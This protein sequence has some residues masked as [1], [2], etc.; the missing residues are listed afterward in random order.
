MENDEMKIMYVGREKRYSEYSGK[1]YYVENS[2]PFALIEYDDSKPSEVSLFDK[3]DEVLSENGYKGDGFGSGNEIAIYY[4]VED[5]A[6]YLHL[7]HL[8]M[9]V[10][11]QK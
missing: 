11:K 6:D 9:Q 5:K 7:K 3:I 10:K 2:T 1:S 4:V 8:Y